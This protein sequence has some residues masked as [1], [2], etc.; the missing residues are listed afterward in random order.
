LL[1]NPMYCGFPVDP[2]LTLKRPTE[3]GYALIAAQIIHEV[4]AGAFLQ[5]FLERL[6]DPSKP[7]PPGTTVVDDRLLSSVEVHPDFTMEHPALVTE[8]EFI[9]A[10]IASIAEMGARRYMEHVL[11]NLKGNWV[12]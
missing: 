6:K 9:E 7:L 1:A 8:T 2:I 10:G 5:N 12:S 4:G 11:E 3:N